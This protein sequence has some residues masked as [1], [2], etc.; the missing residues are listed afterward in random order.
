M[1]NITNPNVIITFIFHTIFIKYIFVIQIASDP[2]R[3]KLEENNY[4]NCFSVKLYN[5][6]FPKSGMSAILDDIY[7]FRKREPTI[8]RIKM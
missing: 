1:V 8:I 3:G 6:E 2:A 7:I 5:L 4:F